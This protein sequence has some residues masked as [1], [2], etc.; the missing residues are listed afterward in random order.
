MER[1]IY[2]E[3]ERVYR[4]EQGSELEEESQDNEPVINSK[5]YHRQI[6]NLLKYNFNI[7]NLDST[8]L[9]SNQRKIERGKSDEE[10]GWWLVSGKPLEAFHVDLFFQHYPETMGIS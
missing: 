6:K 1:D 8:H 3:N 10:H 7:P 4:K 2:L 5:R 9:M